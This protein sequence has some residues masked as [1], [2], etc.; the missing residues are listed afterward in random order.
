[1]RRREE[2]EGEEGRRGPRRVV[3]WEGCYCG[4]GN[5]R[6]GEKERVYRE[7]RKKEGERRRRGR[8]ENGV[9]GVPGGSTRIGECRGWQG[10][11]TYYGGSTI[12]G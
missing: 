1:M 3:G 4:E 12:K 8:R 6:E 10:E 7:E 2:E 11:G 9:V 5:H